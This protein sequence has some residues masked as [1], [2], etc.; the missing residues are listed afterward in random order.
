MTPLSVTRQKDGQ[1]TNQRFVT[2][3]SYN[4]GLPDSL[5][6]AAAIAKPAGTK[7]K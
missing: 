4:K 5:F 3:I 1:N 6:D 2:T 7:K